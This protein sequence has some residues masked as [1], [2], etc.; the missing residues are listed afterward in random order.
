MT[1][2]GDPFRQQASRE[3][4]RWLILLQEDS[5]D[6][7]ISA[8]FDAWLAAAPVNRE[9]W[10]QTEKAMG[11]VARLSP[12]KTCPW[13][14]N[15]GKTVNMLMQPRRRFPKRNA[16]T[17]SAF[18]LAACVSLFLMAPNLLLH[19]R[20]DAMT[21]TAET[22][23][24][25]MA[26][27]SEVTLAPRS[28][29]SINSKDGHRNVTLLAGEALFSVVHDP[30]HSFVVKAGNFTT[31]DIGTVFDVHRTESGV[32]VAVRSGR[33]RVSGGSILAQGRELGAG[34]RLTASATGLHD[35]EQSAEQVGAW[36]DGLLVAN[37]EPLGQVVARLKPYLSGM[38]IV[39][40]HLASQRVS[41]VYSLTDPERALEAVAQ[42][43][44]SSVHR[45]SRWLTVLR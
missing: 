44:Q 33:V 28:A 1:V 18:A 8:Q 16:W 20:A 36:A 10:V 25:H 21:G 3:A 35:D 4:T 45:Y 40:S 42:A 9:A 22:R 15:T 37:D 41:G 13:R 12:G 32:D 19:L 14:D 26:D 2:T 6:P 43:R 23:V 27:G 5:D 11:L 38:V 7:E 24:I 39:P 34:R 17:A 31:T 30:V 29:V